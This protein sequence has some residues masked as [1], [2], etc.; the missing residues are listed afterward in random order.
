MTVL[1]TEAPA[2]GELGQGGLH[3]TLPQ[4]KK[5]AK[6]KNKTCN[7]ELVKIVW[8]RLSRIEKC[9]NKSCL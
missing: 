6:L 8:S 1:H 3:E 4:K 9:Q 7:L 2:P 5:K